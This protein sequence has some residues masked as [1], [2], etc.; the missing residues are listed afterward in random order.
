MGAAAARMSLM[1]GMNV[2]A[3]GPDRIAPASMLA[4]MHLGPLRSIHSIGTETLGRIGMRKITSF[5]TVTRR[6]TFSPPDDCKAL[7]SNS[8]IKPRMAKKLISR[9]PYL[10]AV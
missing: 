7:P 6:T 1:T 3:A 5:W 8:G 9:E 2:A 10:P 4:G